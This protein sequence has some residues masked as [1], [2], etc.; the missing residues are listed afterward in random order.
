VISY[1]FNPFTGKLDAVTD[2]FGFDAN[3]PST[4]SVGDLIYATG[5]LVGGLPQVD[6]VDPTQLIKMPALGIVVDKGSATECS[7]ITCGMVQ[8]LSSLV[9]NA[10]YYV[11]ADGRPTTSV[12]NPRPLFF[13]VI[14]V[15]LDE[16]TLLFQPSFNLVK[17]IP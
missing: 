4:V 16:G 8:V 13:Q 14:G 1:T 5:P 10:R 15:A 11:G 3:C 9:P 7:F 6:R 2:N 12:P 17:L